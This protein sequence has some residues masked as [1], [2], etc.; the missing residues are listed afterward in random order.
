[1]MAA[2]DSTTISASN[3]SSGP[4]RI[5]VRFG[6]CCGGPAGVGEGGRLG[7]SWS[8]L[9]TTA[10][11]LSGPPAWLAAS[12]SAWHAAAGSG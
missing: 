6:R 3:S 12:I 9:I 4:R 11:M 2:V 10:V 5:E 1:M 7:G 8:A